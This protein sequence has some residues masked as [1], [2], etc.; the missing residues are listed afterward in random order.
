MRSG[1]GGGPIWEGVLESYGM[2]HRPGNTYTTIGTKHVCTRKLSEAGIPSSGQTSER[3]IASPGS[4]VGRDTCVC[5]RRTS[6]GCSCTR[7][8]GVL[9]L[10]A[11]CTLD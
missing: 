9:S 6:T 2:G 11:G 8:C 10:I 7:V 1:S 4:Y 3:V 5:G